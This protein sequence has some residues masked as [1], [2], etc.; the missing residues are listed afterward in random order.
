MPDFLNIEEVLYFHQNIKI[1]L[2]EAW[3]I[4]LQT[5]EQ[6]KSNLW[7]KHRQIRL[8]SSAFHSIAHR[9][10]DFDVLAANI[11][12]NHEKD[13]SK[14]PAVSFGSRHESVIRNFIRSQNEC[15]ILRKVGVVTDP[16][17]PFLCASPDGL[18]F[19]KEN[20]QLVEIK[21]C[22]N[23]ENVE[24]NQLAKRPNFCLHNVDGIWKLK[25]TH[26]YFYQIQGQL[27]ISNLTEC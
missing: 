19:N 6:S 4:E 11:Y 23:P 25:T 3:E 8:T 10:A 7:K 1:S 22:Y 20:V 15:Y 2:E 5:T 14:L 21:C 12:R 9:M 17:I 24:L 18:L 26:A 27:A 16:R 13:L